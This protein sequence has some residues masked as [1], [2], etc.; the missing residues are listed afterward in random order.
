MALYNTTEQEL[1][2]LRNDPRGTEEVDTSELTFGEGD[3]MRWNGYNVY[4]LTLDGNTAEVF[5]P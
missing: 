5:I 1:K 2:D 4:V 3:M